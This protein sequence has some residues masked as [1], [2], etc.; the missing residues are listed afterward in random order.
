M[1]YTSYFNKYKGKD[2]ISVANYMPK[3]YMAAEMVYL[4]TK[5]SHV[6][7]FKANLISEE[8][9][10]VHYLNQLSQLDP[11]K[12]FND[13]D[14]SVILCWEKSHQFCHRFILAEWLRSHNISVD[15]KTYED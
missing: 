14:G 11:I 5:W 3:R 15:T 4:A 8:E 13:L 10:K 2:G 12:V 9:F 7:S 6:S 1:I